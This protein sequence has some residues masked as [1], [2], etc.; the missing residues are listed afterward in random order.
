MTDRDQLTVGFPSRSHSPPRSSHATFSPQR[1]PVQYRTGEYVGNDSARARNRPWP[2]WP[3]DFDT[4][5]KS[6]VPDAPFCIHLALITVCLSLFMT[7]RDQLT[8]DFPSRSHS[9]PRSSHAT[10]LP[11]RLPMQY[12]TGE[13]V[14]NDSA[15]ACNHPWPPDFDTSRKS[16]VPVLLSPLPPSPVI[17]ATPSHDNPLPESPPLP[18]D[19]SVTTTTTPNSADLPLPSCDV[20][21]ARM[22]HR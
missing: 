20:C 4:S 17:R 9:P 18:L 7:D 2:P 16:P 11:R 19:L 14:G 12:C 10:F 5:R 13:Y 15:R 1:L 22:D 21:Y 3:P 6:P 8:V